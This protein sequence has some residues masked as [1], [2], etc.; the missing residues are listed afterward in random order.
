MPLLTQTIVAPRPFSP[1]KTALPQDAG[2]YPRE[3]LFQLLDGSRQCSVIWVSGPPG[4]GKTA[5]LSSYPKAR[6]LPVLWYQVDSRDQDP[7]N[8]FYYLGLAAQ[9]LGPANKPDLPLL[10]A[11]YLANL[12]TFTKRYFRELYS[13]LEGPFVLVLDDCHEMEEKSALYQVLQDSLSELPV[14]ATVI[15]V[16]RGT[17]PPAF[18]RLRL[19][20]KMKIIDAQDL[21]LTSD[22][23]RDIA[24][25]RGGQT[26]ETMLRLL[27]DKTGGWA[28]GLVLML[29]HAQTHT[30]LSPA[31]DQDA[32]QLIFD[33]FADEIFAKAT[34]DMQKFLLQSAFFPCMT[35]E[36]V[37]QLTGH[38][39]AGEMLADLSRRHYF[40]EK[41]NGDGILYQYN[42]LFRDF[43]LS[44]S[45]RVFFAEQLFDTQNRAAHILEKAG[46]V[47]EAIALYI[48]IAN[49]DM[50]REA[51]LRHAAMLIAQGRTQTLESW[52]HA[53]PNHVIEQNGWL[54]YWL[55]YCRLP[56]NIAE[57]R[58]YHEKAYAFFKAEQ[59]PAG[60]YLA[61]AGVVDTYRYEWGNFTPLDHWIGELEDML[62]RHPHFPSI[63][64]EIRV[65]SSMFGTLIYHR[66]QHP[67]LPAWEERLK[68]LM[69]NC[70]DR[71]QRLIMGIN[72][73]PYYFWLGDFAKA[74]MI[75]R[76]LEEE[77][78]APDVPALIKITWQLQEGFY[79]SLAGTTE[80][81]INAVE[82]GWRIVTQSGVHVR[83]YLLLGQGA[84][85]ALVA[86]DLELAKDYLRRMAPV[87]NATRLL[88]VG[89]YHYQAAWL[90]M[91]QSN[92]PHALEDAE[93]A[94]RL[95]TA[96]GTPFPNAICLIGLTQILFAQGRNRAALVH[97][98]RA[99]RIGRSMRSELIEYHCLARLALY[100]LDRGR[101]ALGI[102]LLRR[103]C[104]LNKKMGSVNLHFWTR[105]DIARLCAYALEAG[106][107]TDHIRYYV[108]QRGLDLADAGTHCEEW[109]WPLKIYTLGRFQVLC[110]DEP[111]SL[112]S[113]GQR[114]P[115][116]LLKALLAFGGRD[117]G[118]DQLAE[119]LWP[120][121]EGDIARQAFNTTLHRLRKVLDHDKVLVLQSGRLSL[122]AHYC[123]VDVW[124]LGRAMSR[125]QD[126][127][128]GEHKDPA[129]L[130]KVFQL[131][132]GPFLHQEGSAWA[133]TPR[134]RLKSKF[135]RQLDD[136]GQRCEQTGEWDAA[137]DCYGKSLEVDPVA[138]VFYQR[139]MRSYLRQNRRAEA[140]AVYQR[141]RK[142]LNAVLAMP[143]SAETEAIRRSLQID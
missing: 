35:T 20:R 121:A 102:S 95:S 129:S 1:A 79:N 130:R 16:S 115:L 113:K 108:R 23:I 83:D 111:I 98:G 93:T 81:C 70:P 100:A 52:I 105:T 73:L 118:V 64:I 6:G 126:R 72:L 112:S 18:A 57:A 91:L 134:E 107:E 104:A 31:I 114:K 45:R 4:S 75:F 92:L 101:Q 44:Q 124:A 15:L 76:S 67:R 51:I 55:G 8:F 38:A 94:V 74:W 29:E 30:A 89:Y 17:P 34:P 116:E 87:L 13:R 59:H 136:L 25:I 110:H 97:L 86:G 133:I 128:A 62:E 14:D 139:L 39:D 49:W 99:R 127:Q 43:L 58:G 88:D 41:R 36:M 140:L 7:A 69:Q 63:E 123:W 42:G 103:V 68:T 106:I 47:D 3:R 26:D 66:P 61:W 90:A 71:N 84:V 77:V 22:E 82:E 137:V 65:L 141:C 54:L 24:A 120:D 56:F 10:T 60:Q 32:F 138:E 50:A 21:C 80:H 19:N 78:H 119:A 122:E 85:G 40:V 135:L 5:L 96:A 37:V 53:L 48:S 11:E 117:I 28:A 132:Q 46:Q 131:Y 143:P 12:P 27:Y 33:Y 109:P 125:L 142:V 2:V 9:H